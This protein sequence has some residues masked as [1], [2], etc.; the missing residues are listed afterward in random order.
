MSP[1]LFLEPVCIGS[2]IL[3]VKP[4]MPLIGCLGLRHVTHSSD[5]ILHSLVPSDNVNNINTTGAPFLSCL[6][7]LTKNTNR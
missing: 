1:H 3:S 4:L 2:L 6:Y 7:V 5:M